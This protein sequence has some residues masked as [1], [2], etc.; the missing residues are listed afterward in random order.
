MLTKLFVILGTII[1]GLF[2]LYVQFTSTWNCN[3]QLDLG[4]RDLNDRKAAFLE[5]QQKLIMGAMMAAP[6]EEPVPTF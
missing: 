4:M 1:I 2:I 5:D 3:M 6:A